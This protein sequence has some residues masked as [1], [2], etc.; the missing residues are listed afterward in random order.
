MNAPTKRKPSIVEIAPLAPVSD[1]LTVDEAA[2]YLRVSACWIYDHAAG[3]REP[4]IPCVR[5]GASIRFRRSTLD[6]MI[7]DLEEKSA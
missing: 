7:A 2:K 5:L 4:K 6:R 3:R 1:M